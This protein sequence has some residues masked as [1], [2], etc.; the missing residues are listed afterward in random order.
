[1]VYQPEGVSLR[2]KTQPE[3]NE[4]VLLRNELENA[5][6]QVVYQPEGVS[7]RFKTQPEANA[8]RLIRLYHRNDQL[9][10]KLLSGRLS[11]ASGSRSADAPLVVRWLFLARV[12]LLFALITEQ[13]NVLL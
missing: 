3:A 9:Q 13:L 1:M 11:Q 12:K 7:L 5:D 6:L 8:F 4:S 10:F 2:F